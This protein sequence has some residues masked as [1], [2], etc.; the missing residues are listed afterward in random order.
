[1]FLCWSPGIKLDLVV[2]VT[3]RGKTILYQFQSVL[4]NESPDVIE[5]FQCMGF[6]NSSVETS[7]AGK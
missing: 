2:L 6:M 4:I 5:F 3:G 7:V 1:M